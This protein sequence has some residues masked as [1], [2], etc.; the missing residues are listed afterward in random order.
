MATISQAPATLDLVTVK[1]DD[2][3]VTL[4]VTENGAAYDWTG[5]TVATSILDAS[6]TEVATDFT[7]STPTNGTLQLTLTDANTTTLGVATYRWQVNV[8]KG[9]L[10]RTWLAG[11]LSVMQ[12]GWGGTSTSSASLSITTGA[13]TLALSLIS[14]GVDRD[15][16]Y[17]WHQRISGA[18]TLPR[19]V[20]TSGSASTGTQNLRLSFFTAQSSFTA[21]NAVIA[22]GATAA[23]ATPS[24]IRVGL[25]TV[26]SNGD[27]TLVA[28]TA[29]DTS[30]LASANTIYVKA[31]SASYAVTKG[32]RYALGLLVVTATTAPTVVGQFPGSATSAFP[33]LSPR[34]CGVV[35]SQAD[36]PAT[37]AS[38]SIT[39]SN[40][41]QWLALTA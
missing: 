9:S 24:L 5:A 21:A 3:T 23:A 40:I 11:A 14:G 34:L 13:A 18:E 1:G 37:V 20:A 33:G 16:D 30:L 2:L 31:L 26:A 38:A 32:Q 35:A 28:S 36:L 41:H 29:S 22:G 15:E 12:P 17:W 19:L 4:T 25:Y 39:N 10:T 27:L 7:V 8:T 6:G